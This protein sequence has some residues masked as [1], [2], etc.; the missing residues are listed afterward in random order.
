M[1]RATLFFLSA[2][3][4]AL[5][6]ATAAIAASTTAGISVSRGQ[7]DSMAYSLGI[8][9]RYDPW[10]S[11]DIF[12]F[13]SLAEIGGHAWVS[14]YSDT[15]TVWGGFL[16]PGL[17]FTLHT[18]KDIQPYLE[19][20]VGGAL[21]N[22]NKFDDRQLGSQL[23]LRSR[24]SVGVGFGEGGRHRIQGDY[25]NYSTGGLTRKNDGF[26]TYGISYGF[27]F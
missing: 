15:D 10:I 27:S 20:T 22:R 19:A 5:C 3:L 26:N 18:D 25:I 17:R 2:L 24:G 21:N 16:A 1:K 13:A 8:K 12:E 14:R 9:Q 7:G 11:S 4:V 23:L 6:M